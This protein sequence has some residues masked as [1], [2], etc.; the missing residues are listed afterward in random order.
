[1]HHPTLTWPTC[2]PFSLHLVV[3]QLQTGSEA[4]LRAEEA[5]EPLKRWWQSKQSSAPT[6]YFTSQEQ[7]IPGGHA[8]HT[9]EAHQSSG[10][11]GS[12]SS[13]AQHNS[14][15]SSWS[16]SNSNEDTSQGKQLQQQQRQLVSPGCP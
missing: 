9:E 6:D 16:N 12:N 3:V 13:S 7:D 5:S 2:T 4:S 1:M 11:G 14:E 10:P 15:T 8:S